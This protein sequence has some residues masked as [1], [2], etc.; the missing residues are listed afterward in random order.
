MEYPKVEITTKTFVD[1]KHAYPIYLCYEEDGLEF[2]YTKIEKYKRTTIKRDMI[3]T[4]VE[5]FNSRTPFNLNEDYE[6]RLSDAETFN[7]A[8]NHF[9]K[10]I[11]Q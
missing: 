9:L 10:N 11:Q 5:V 3:C 2:E 1:A 7:E 8:L 6:H 4:T